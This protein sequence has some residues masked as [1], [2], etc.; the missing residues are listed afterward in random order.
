MKV[1]ATA[2]KACG[3]QHAMR[4]MMGTSG[5]RNSALN[6]LDRHTAAEA[7]RLC[8]AR[9]AKEMATSL[10]TRANRAFLNQVFQFQC[11]TAATAADF[12]GFVEP[13]LMLK[14]TGMFSINPAVSR[15]MT[16]FLFAFP[17]QSKRDA[18]MGLLPPAH[19]AVILANIQ[20]DSEHYF[21]QMNFTDIEQM[22]E[23]ISIENLLRCAQAQ[24]ARV[25]RFG[26]GQDSRQLTEAV[27][28]R[29]PRDL[30]TSYSAWKKARGRI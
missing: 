2:Q 12:M 6:T 7:I 1:T 21:R 18:I 10:F 4:M 25:W 5:A 17:D 30:W 8:P 11:I 14:E 13:F 16:A 24:P 28:K 19:K 22:F 29:M 9:D 3:V 23:V 26:L 27:F 15:D 20:G